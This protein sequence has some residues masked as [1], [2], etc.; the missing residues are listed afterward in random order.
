MPAGDSLHK[1]GLTKTAMASEPQLGS[2]ALRVHLARTDWGCR[3]RPAGRHSRRWVGR[4]EASSTTCRSN[5]HSPSMPELGDTDPQ[6]VGAGVGEEH[7][8][9]LRDGGASPPRP[10]SAGEQLSLARG[11]S[12]GRFGCAPRHPLPPDEKSMSPR[13]VHKRRPQRESRLLF[14]TCSPWPLMKLA[15]VS[16][17]AAASSGSLLNTDLL[18]RAIHEVSA[19]VI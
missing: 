8:A 17:A 6:A 14:R 11:T 7:V 15:R 10:I 5:P 2:A 13:A 4:S 1:S 12:I 3:T 9:Q 19:G 18:A 16:S